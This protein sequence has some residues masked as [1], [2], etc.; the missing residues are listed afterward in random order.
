MS[1]IRAATSKPH[2]DWLDAESTEGQHRK[3][4]EPTPRS[5]SPRPAMSIEMDV[6]FWREN[7]EAVMSELG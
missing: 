1:C 2:A 4:P 3:A 6:N 7:A 5:T